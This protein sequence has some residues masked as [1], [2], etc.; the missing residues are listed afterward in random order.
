MCWWQIYGWKTLF[1]ANWL[2]LNDSML[3]WLHHTVSFTTFLV[4][5]NCVSFSD[6]RPAPL[7]PREK[8]RRQKNKDLAVSSYP[9]IKLRLQ[10]HVLSFQVLWLQYRL[11]LCS[12][13]LNLRIVVALVHVVKFDSFRLLELVEKHIL[14]MSW[15]GT[16]YWNRI[17]VI[18]DT[19]VCWWR[20]ESKHVE[21]LSFQSPQFYFSTSVV[22]SVVQQSGGIDLVFR[23]P[24]VQRVYETKNRFCK[25]LRQLQIPFC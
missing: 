5:L 24:T 8:L 17:N 2:T 20:L 12:Y 25:C 9:T 22:F 3:Q 21:V 19:L 1:H 10:L 11:V 4:E 13:N 16:T 15:T 23:K 18:T 6:G 7:G 14:Q